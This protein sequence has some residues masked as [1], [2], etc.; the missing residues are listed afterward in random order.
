MKAHKLKLEDSHED[1]S[2]GASSQDSF[3]FESEEEESEDEQNKG[4]HIEEL[5]FWLLSDF[6]F[7]RDKDH[8]T[9]S[10]DKNNHF[11]IFDGSFQQHA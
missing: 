10:Q 9:L 6:H 8:Q 5:T 11:I 4:G 3:A 2:D 7:N 1:S